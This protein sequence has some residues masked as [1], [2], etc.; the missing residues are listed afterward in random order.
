MTERQ[1]EQPP[2][3]QETLLKNNIEL[4]LPRRRRRRL[5]VRN[6]VRTFGTAVFLGSLLTVW[7]ELVRQGTA[8]AQKNHG[9]NAAQCNGGQMPCGSCGAKIPRPS[10]EQIGGRLSCGCAYWAGLG[11]KVRGDAR[12]L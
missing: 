1:S 4:F 7:L 8:K 11:G 3:P 6:D 2:D 5:T 10:D 9:T 12:G